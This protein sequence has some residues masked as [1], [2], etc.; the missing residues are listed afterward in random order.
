M[1][2][3]SDFSHRAGKPPV[4]LAT[5]NRAR[6]YPLHPG[7]IDYLRRNDPLVD[8]QLLDRLSDLKS[9]LLSGVSSLVLLWTWLR[10]RNTE[11]LDDYFHE[12]S[13]WEIE[14]WQAAQS[15]RLDA[16]RCQAL[17]ARLME[18]KIT[19]LEKQREGVLAVETQLAALLARFEDARRSLEAMPQAAEPDA[20]SWACQRRAA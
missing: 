19:V 11:R 4:D 14:A 20:A 17:L 3:E 15:G 8:R 16:D 10:R 9:F 13:Q 5:S 6:R 18:M 1:I 7:V 2:Y 12:V